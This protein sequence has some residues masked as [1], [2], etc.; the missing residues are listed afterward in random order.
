MP[1]RL[2]SARSFTSMSSIAYWDNFYKHPS[3]ASSSFDWFDVDSAHSS[4]IETVCAAVSP[5][6]SAAPLRVLHIGA[7]TSVLCEALHEALPTGSMLVHADYSEIAAAALEERLGDTLAVDAH[8]VVQSDVRSMTL[9]SLGVD[10]PFDVVVDKGCIDVFVHGHDDKGFAQALS[11]IR[12]VLGRGGEEGGGRYVMITNDSV[13]CRLD[14]LLDAG[15]A[16]MFHL[17][18]MTTRQLEGGGVEVNLL[19]VRARAGVALQRR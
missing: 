1:R 18:E 7:G 6:A 5:P 4:S 11:S 19:Q 14:M 3:R 15:G 2:L 17:G 8:R 9:G 16:K 13:D 12:E 10:E